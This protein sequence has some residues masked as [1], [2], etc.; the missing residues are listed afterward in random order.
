MFEFSSSVNKDNFNFASGYFL[1]CEIRAIVRKNQTEILNG[2]LEI[3]LRER[4]RRGLKTGQIRFGITSVVKKPVRVPFIVNENK[5]FHEPSRSFH[6][7]TWKTAANRGFRLGLSFFHS[8]FAPKPTPWRITLG[9]SR[10]KY[11]ISYSGRD[12]NRIY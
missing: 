1:G 11:L 7:A 12:S 3:R 4:V 5:T 9:P 8:R 10:S 6:N 2:F